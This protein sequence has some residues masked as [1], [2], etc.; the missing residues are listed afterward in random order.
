MRKRQR[1]P[2]RSDA[3]LTRLTQVEGR[4]TSPPWASGVRS[5]EL[6][7]VR[8]L[9]DLPL[10]REVEA[11]PATVNPDRLGDLRRPPDRGPD[12]R[13]VRAVLRS[14]APPK[15]PPAGPGPSKFPVPPPPCR[16]ASSHPHGPRHRVS[17]VQAHKAH[18]RPRRAGDATMTG[19]QDLRREGQRAPATARCPVCGFTAPTTA[20][21]DWSAAARTVTDLS[22]SQWPARAA[23]LRR[24]HTPRWTC[25]SRTSE[26]GTS[27]A[28]LGFGSMAPRSGQSQ[29]QTLGHAQNGPS[30]GQ[31]AAMARAA[32]ACQH[33]S[34]S[35]SSH[36]PSETSQRKSPERRSVPS[37]AAPQTT[38][39]RETST[40]VLPAL[41]GPQS[42]GVRLSSLLAWTSR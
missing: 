25:G 31:M 28:V 2:S 13:Q 39:H 29:A 22:P 20:A 35:G 40:E 16:V 21:P 6:S 3:S 12:M 37:R 15:P 9:Q 14:S 32:N 34:P 4:A 18:Q 33:T 17:A 11:D 23:R 38:K 1:R 5:P 8:R 19:P 30:G 10:L 26:P 7:S 42:E 27:A 24:R 41:L 36:R